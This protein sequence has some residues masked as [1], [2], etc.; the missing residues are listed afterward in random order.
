MGLANIGS[1]AVVEPEEPDWAGM[2]EEEKSAL[3]KELNEKRTKFMA[4]MEITREERHDAFIALREADKAAQAARARS[5]AA[6]KAFQVAA[7]N[8]QRAW[9]KW[10]AAERAP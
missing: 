9:E 1:A 5:D 2:T 8:Y 7:F 4:Q 3:A 6:E 10:I